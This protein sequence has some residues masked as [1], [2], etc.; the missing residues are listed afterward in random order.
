MYDEKYGGVFNGLW[1]QKF[2]VYKDILYLS[3]NN[4]LEEY[5]SVDWLS[6]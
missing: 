4:T 5:D 3:G 1:E 6:Q 2:Q